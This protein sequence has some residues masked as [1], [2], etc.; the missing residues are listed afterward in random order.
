M[1]AG[2]SSQE[3]LLICAY[4]RPDCA[5]VLSEIN[6]AVTVEEDGEVKPCSGTKSNCEIVEVGWRGWIHVFI[7]TVRSVR[8]G[9][10]LTVTYGEVPRR[11]HLRRRHQVSVSSKLAAT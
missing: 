5:N 9:D 10:E 4:P 11:L 7:V 8:K 2:L 1:E 6:D 3:P